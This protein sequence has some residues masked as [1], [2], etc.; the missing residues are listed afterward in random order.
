MKKSD[1]P[2]NKWPTFM[3]IYIFLYLFP[4]YNFLSHLYYLFHKPWQ[5]C[6]KEQW[7]E[8]FTSFEAYEHFRDDIGYFV[9]S[10]QPE[11]HLLV[12]NK[13]C[14]CF[15]WSYFE[16]DR[17][18]YMSVVIVLG[19]FEGIFFL[20]RNKWKWI[21]WTSGSFGTH[22]LSRDVIALVHLVTSCFGGRSFL[23]CR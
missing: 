16:Y 21:C 3:F 18:G 15:H 9:M 13:N 17:T 23:W 11:F 7:M 1:Y 20:S 8:A 12:N 4:K 22:E 6:S 14:L 5:F 19:N 10:L 2:Q